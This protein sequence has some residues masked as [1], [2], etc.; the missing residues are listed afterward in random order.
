MAKIETQIN[1]IN[2]YRKGLASVLTFIKEIS[3]LKLLFVRK[4]NNV[5]TVADFF[6]EPDGS[7][8]ATSPEGYVAIDHTGGA[9]KFVDRLEFSRRNFMAKDF[10]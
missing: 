10:G 8:T 4:L 7:Y 6:R 5:E 2:Q 9:V 1:L 3:N